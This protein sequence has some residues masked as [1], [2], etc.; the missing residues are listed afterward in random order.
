[1]LKRNHVVRLN[2]QGASKQNGVVKWLGKDGVGTEYAVVR[3]DN[4]SLLLTPCS[5]LRVQIIQ[6]ASESRIGRRPTQRQGD[7][8]EEKK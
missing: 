6:L 7:L 4:G 5:H 1:M 8:K 3:F 2:M